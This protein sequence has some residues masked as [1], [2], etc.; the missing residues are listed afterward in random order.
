MITHK[1]CSGNGKA[2]GYGCGALIPVEKRKYGLGIDCCYKDWLLNSEAGKEKLN[3]SILH[4]KKET[5]K[6]ESAKT[7][8]AKE[9]LK[10]RSDW[11]NNLQKEINAIVRLI[12]KDHPCISSNRPLGKSY[13]AGHLLGRQSHP[14]IRY[15]LFNIFAQSVHDNQW[16][17]GNQLEFVNGIEKTFGA[18][19]KDYCLS[20]KGLPPLKLTIDEIKEKIYLARSIVKWLKL[21]DRKFDISERIWLRKQ[22]NSELD[23]YK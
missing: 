21:Q 19:I 11:E 10:T 6:T 22:F 4:A 23:I 7:K 3:K 18:E 13:D 16:K 20:L 12:D 15:N 17:S 9:K 5:K 2:I 8:E 14:Q 1:K